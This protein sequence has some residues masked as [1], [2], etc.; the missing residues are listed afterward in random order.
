MID[1]CELRFGDTSN[2]VRTEA[3][4]L[5]Y[6]NAAYREFIRTAKWPALLTET[7]LN[8][9]GGNPTATIPSAALQGGLVDVFLST[10]GPLEPVPADLA[11]NMRRFL[12]DQESASP[13]YW[14]RRG[15]RLNV[16]PT[17]AG[18]IT[19]TLSYIAAV[20]ALAVGTSPVIP[21]TY[22]SA[23]IAGA[24]ARAHADDDN[25]QLAEVFQAEFS[26]LAEVARRDSEGER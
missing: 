26:R 9:T 4:W 18:N 24:L 1:A 3:E 23:L 22:H 25:P 6:I 5:A 17:P 8:F 11:P 12:H 21:E 15:A 16:L 10:G 20:S 14:E 2:A 13:V 7:T 19:L